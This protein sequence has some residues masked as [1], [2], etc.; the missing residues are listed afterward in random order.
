MPAEFHFLRPG[1]LALLALVP[2]LV[3]VTWRR[4]GAGGRWADVVAPA[5]RE[6]VLVRRVVERRGRL[7][8][9]VA[10]LSLALGSL[11]LAGPAWERQTE[12]L[13]RGDDAL[14]VALDLSRSMDV[15]DVA[16][17]RLTRA[18][19]K[20]LDLLERRNDGQTGLIVYSAN[21]F[22][23]V[24]LTNDND[25]IA[26]L[27]NSLST[28]I[29]PSRGS[30]PASALRKAA[31]LL[32]QSGAVRGRVLL[33]TDGGYSEAAA[34]AARQL[35]EAGYPVSVLGVGTVQGGPVP[36]PG[37]GFETMRDGKV[38]IARLQQGDLTRLAYAGGGRYSSLTSDGS[39]I[40][41]L[42]GASAGS[43]VRG[44]DGDGGFGQTV[45]VWRDQGPW[46]VLALLPLAA[47]L[48]RRGFVLSVAGML[49]AAPPQAFANPAADWFLTPDQ[50]GAQA[51]DDGD[52]AAAAELF[53]DPE[54]RAAALYR[55]QRY[56][57]SAAALADIDAVE[58]HYNRGNALA[59]SGDFDAAIAA[60]EAALALA[61]EHADARYNKALLERERDRQNDSG[62]QGQGGDSSESGGEE[63]DRQSAGGQ[64]ADGDQGDDGDPG[65][66]DER[67]PDG[68]DTGDG[69]SAD[70]D[71][72]ARSGDSEAEQIEALRQALAE[73]A[74]QQNGD[75]EQPASSAAMSAEARAEQEREEAIDQWLRRVPDDPG[76]LLRRKFRDQYRRLG[77]DQDGNSLWPDNEEE[78]W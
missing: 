58:A 17:S 65:R 9:W 3:W 51:L 68:S 44:R 29:M 41:R 77:R 57:E 21:A 31:A 16:P 69:S 34:A 61:P 13:Y 14:V 72:E 75:D 5:L 48:F 59:R 15:A 66:P 76:G 37:G 38:A 23:V 7:L 33:V 60:Y 30:Y 71:G 20:L 47:L 73:Q 64:D 19:L 67:R 26:A 11:A 40:D 28:D 62:G 32:E 24:P 43:A 49:V 25:T 22:T 53:D 46:L 18:K 4:G 55:A 50:Q 54:W 52:A 35:N 56:G 74:G 1:W 36:M 12:T 2:L 8:P 45:E 27:V 10:G 78:P 70:S 42:I 39:D 6:Y 63:G